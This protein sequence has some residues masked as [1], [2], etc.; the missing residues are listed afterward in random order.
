MNP[1]LIRRKLTV[2]QLS[3]TPT[4][5]LIGRAGSGKTTLTNKLSEINHQYAF[6]L[7]DT[8]NTQ[9]DSK[10]SI[11]TIFM[12]I[13]YDTRFEKMI[14]AYFELEASVEN[15]TDKI[16]V[17]IS[18]WDQSKNPKED[19]KEIGD[20]FTEEC[21]QL[22]NMIFY[23]EQYINAELALL[24]YSCVSNIHEIE[25]DAIEN[26]S[27]E[28][29]QE[30]DNVNNCSSTS[31]DVSTITNDSEYVN[32][33]STV[34]NSLKRTY[35]EY[36]LDSEEFSRNISQSMAND[37][38]KRMKSENHALPLWQRCLNFCCIS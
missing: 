2:R 34:K 26:S 17:M 35:D 24:M 19:F 28:D 22:V 27:F 10:Q 6:I 20:L 18:H 21:P 15:D 25:L 36:Q 31:C 37:N 1:I 29:C 3:Y 13:K 11:N 30:N 32:E 16:V 14:T 38:A 9:L 5:L 12:I 4:A 23:S 8:S 7:I 33:E